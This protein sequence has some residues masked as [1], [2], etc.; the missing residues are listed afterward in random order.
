VVGGGGFGSSQWKKRSGRGEPTRSGNKDGKSPKNRL[1]S[2]HRSGRPF[3]S[4]KSKVKELYGA[5][6][7]WSREEEVKGWGR[8]SLAGVEPTSG[9]KNCGGGRI[10]RGAKRGGVAW[11][12]SGQGQTFGVGSGKMFLWGKGAGDLSPESG[13]KS[14]GQVRAALPERGAIDGRGARLK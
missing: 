7:S 12:V 4:N 10:H 11:F 5:L 2:R 14:R 6:K 8:Q 13:T 9:Q 3:R 1:S